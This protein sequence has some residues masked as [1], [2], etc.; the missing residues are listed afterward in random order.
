MLTA[1]P[2]SGNITMSEI[3]AN[4]NSGEATMNGLKKS[5]CLINRELNKMLPIFRKQITQYSCI[6]PHWSVT[7]FPDHAFPGAPGWFMHETGKSDVAITP[8]MVKSLAGYKV[9]QEL[10]DIGDFIAWGK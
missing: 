4:V 5:F 2:S 3:V 10:K 9:M 6:N 7:C 1:T 8:H